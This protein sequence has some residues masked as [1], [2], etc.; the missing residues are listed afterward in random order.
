MHRT[1]MERGG[2][3]NKGHRY[4]VLGKDKADF[5]IQVLRSLEDDELAQ[6][7]SVEGEHLIC[8]SYSCEKIGSQVLAMVSDV[9]HDR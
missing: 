9:A 1:D 5:V 7:I 8:R 3:T 6:R 2:D 4:D